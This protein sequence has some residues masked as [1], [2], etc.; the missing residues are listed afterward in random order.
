MTVLRF[1]VC[2]K[3]ALVFIGYSL[4]KSPTKLLELIQMIVCN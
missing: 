1:K 3:I 4:K 2:T